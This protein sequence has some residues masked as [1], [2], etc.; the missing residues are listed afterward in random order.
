[1]LLLSFILGKERSTWFKWGCIFVVIIGIL[2]AG[3][4]FIL[5]FNG[6]RRTAP[7]TASMVAMIEPV[8]AS[9]FGV[10]VIGTYLTLIQLLGMVLIL[11]TITVFSVKQATEKAV[12]K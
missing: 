3:I 7:T 6:I 5:Y 1:V 10:L 9:L 4:S 11:A 2:G 8:T 12:E